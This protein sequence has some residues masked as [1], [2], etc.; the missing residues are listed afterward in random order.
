M[1]CQQQGFESKVAQLSWGDPVWV[2]SANSILEGCK[3]PGWLG[4]VVKYMLKRKRYLEDHP[5]TW[6]RGE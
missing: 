1:E 2:M 3:L 5:R 6:I 4:V